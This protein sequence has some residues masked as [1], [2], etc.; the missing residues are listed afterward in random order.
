MEH[1]TRHRFERFGYRPEPGL[2]ADPDP[3]ELEV[4]AQEHARRKRKWRRYGMAEL[5]RRH[6]S[7]RHPVAAVPNPK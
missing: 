6:I 7:Y 4:V 3:A 1:V 2:T 5:K